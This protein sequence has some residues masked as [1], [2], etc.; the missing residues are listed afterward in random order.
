VSCRTAHLPKLLSV[1]S[2]TRMLLVC[3]ARANHPGDRAG[4]SRFSDS[5]FS[6]LTPRQLAGMILRPRP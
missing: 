5:R 2:R 3:G 6:D 4:L 1:A